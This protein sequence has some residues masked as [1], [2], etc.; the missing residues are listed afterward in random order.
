MSGYLD[1]VTDKKYTLIVRG[2]VTLNWNDLEFLEDAIKTVPN[3][4]G[5]FI[6]YNEPGLAQYDEDRYLRGSK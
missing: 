4:H 2:E 3:T 1:N 6:H 5:T